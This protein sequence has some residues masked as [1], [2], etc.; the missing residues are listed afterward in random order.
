MRL[1]RAWLPVILWAALILSASNDSF[2]SGESKSWLVEFFGREVPEAINI[3]VRKFGHIAVYAVLGILAWRAERRLVIAM[4]V[5]AIVAI[6]DEAKQS[7]TILRS[8]SPWDVLLDVFG[9]WLGTI[10][11][12]RVWKNMSG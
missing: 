8:G 12:R 2:A 11:G 4:A 3:V 5:A 7:T 6:A 9:A 1:V 10:A